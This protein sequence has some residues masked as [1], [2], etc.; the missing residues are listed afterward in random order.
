MIA[1]ELQN[2]MTNT[3]L[4]NPKSLNF[5]IRASN[6]ETKRPLQTC[7][8][9]LVEMTGYPVSMYIANFRALHTYYIWFT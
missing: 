6:F 1:Y 2:I 5:V 7:N 9:L 8:G 4:R 3:E